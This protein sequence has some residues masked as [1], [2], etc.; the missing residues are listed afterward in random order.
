[1]QNEISLVW[2]SLSAAGETQSFPRSQWSNS[3]IFACQQPLAIGDVN[4]CLLSFPSRR[5][6]AADF[7]CSGLAQHL[8]L[9][10]SMVLFP[11]LFPFGGWQRGGVGNQQP[12]L[13]QQTLVPGGVGTHSKLQS[14]RRDYFKLKT[15]DSQQMQYKRASSDLP[16]PD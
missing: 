12:H 16:F 2:P 3:S 4:P 9:P 6:P 13:H 5:A 10:H 1:M 8:G 7:E 15:F 11:S 14:G